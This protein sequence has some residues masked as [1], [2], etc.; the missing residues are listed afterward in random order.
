MHQDV[1]LAYIHANAI[2][3]TVKYEIQYSNLI[4]AKAY[5]DP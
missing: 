3:I 2:G 1:C 4:L 5:K